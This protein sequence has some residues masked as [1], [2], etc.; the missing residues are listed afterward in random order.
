M[1]K[2]FPGFLGPCLNQIVSVLPGA[3]LLAVAFF[4]P[5]KAGLSSI[6]TINY[7]VEIYGQID[8]ILRVC[9]MTQTLAN[10]QEELCDL[11]I[12]S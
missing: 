12:K 6:D 9:I 7:F 1:D 4:T 3:M 10:N 5:K 2:G 8:F 11:L